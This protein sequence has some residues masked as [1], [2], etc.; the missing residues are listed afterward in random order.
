[1]PTILGPLNSLA[2]CSS[3]LSSSPIFLPPLSLHNLQTMSANGHAV[4]PELP[5]GHFLFTSESVGEGHP[6]RF[7]VLLTFCTDTDCFIQI[8]FVTRFP[9]PL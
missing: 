8:R 9:M 6:G 3:N 7:I 4:R 1:M 2:F 5:H